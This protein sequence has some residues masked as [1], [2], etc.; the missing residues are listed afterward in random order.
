MILTVFTPGAYIALTCFHH[1]MIPENLLLS[2]ISAK[3]AVPFPTIIEVLLMLMI[4]DIIRESGQRLPRAMGQ[5]VSIVGAVVLGQA[6]VEARFVS[7]P[8]IIII[9]ITAIS[10][11]IFLV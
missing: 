2:F 8:V 6:A 1:E 9:A 3:N 4:F 11:F 5:T 10:S 7:A